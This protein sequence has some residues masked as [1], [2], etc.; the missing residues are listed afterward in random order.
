MKSKFNCVV[1]DLDGTLFSSHESIYYC[2]LK[3]FEKLGMS[4]KIPKDEFNKMIGLHF[5]EIFENF[6]I[7]NVDFD[8]FIKIYK[9]LYFDFIDLTKPHDGL[10]ETINELK[11]RNIKLA[12]LTTKSQVQAERIMQHF[13]LE[14]EFDLI[15]GR[16]PGFAI[17]PD[18]MPLK[19]I[20]EELNCSASESLIVGDAE[21]DVQCGKAAG[22]KTVAVTMGYRS[23]EELQKESPDYLI[24]G[25]LELLRIVNG[26]KEN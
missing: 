17:K 24:D 9:E 13:N 21:I 10:Y 22:T 25:L 7:E 19:A 20:L 26:Y 14:K 23:K 16:R 15:M 1:F 18:P 11:N 2:T 6:G 3:T 12:L 8:E 5:V 4:P